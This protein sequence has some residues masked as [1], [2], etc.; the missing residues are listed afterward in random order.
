M[1]QV[2][3]LRSLPENCMK[4]SAFLGVQDFNWGCICPDNYP[5]LCC[6]NGLLTLIVYVLAR[7]TDHHQA[8]VAGPAP[9]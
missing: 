2:L 5:V 4:G 1:L 7:S 3:K 9:Y 6:L 8:A